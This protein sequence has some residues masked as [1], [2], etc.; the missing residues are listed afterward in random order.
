LSAATFGAAE[1]ITSRGTALDGRHRAGR[2]AP[3]TL[4]ELTEALDAA[5]IDTR[6]QPVVRIADRVPVGIEVLARLE[7]PSRGTLAP[8]LF[9][10]QIEDAGLAVPLT[11]AVIGR[12]FADWGHDRLDELGLSL[13]LNFPLDVLLVPDVLSWLDERRQ[14]AGI[15][16]RRVTVELTES[17]PLTRVCELREAVGRLRHAGY[18]VAIDDVGPDVRDHLPLLDMNFSVLKLDKGLVQ[19]NRNDLAAQDFLVRTI[20]AGHAAGLVIVAEGVEDAA[21][22]DHMAELGVD[23]AQGFLIAQPMPAAAVPVW[24]G[25]WCARHRAPCA[26]GA[27]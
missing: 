22:W 8:D 18:G 17:R 2:D 27:L 13:A 21:G 20:A 15:P 16:V 11:R 3:V 24:Q 23:E 14:R 25:E 5:R 10:P 1:A 4:V 7:H 19:R 9:I 12:A 26:G 6:Y